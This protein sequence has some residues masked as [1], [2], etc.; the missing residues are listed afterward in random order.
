VSGY[1]YIAIEGPIG[2][3]KSTLA[4]L[5]QGEFEA[6][7]L[8]EV[9]E[10]N[11]FLSNFYADRDQYAFQVQLFFLLSRYRQQSVVPRLVD[12]G[13]VIS[14]YT[15]AKD[16]LFAHLNVRGDEL[17]LYD[18]LHALLS[19]KLLEPDLIVYL[20][21]SHNALMERI[22]IRDREYERNMDAEYMADLSRAYD[23]FFADYAACP[24]VTID[25][26]DLNIVRNPEDLGVILER[27]RSVLGH[28]THQRPLLDVGADSFQERNAALFERAE[29]RLP[30]LQSWHLAFDR[31][32]G[33]STDLSVNFICLQEEIGELAT[34]VLGV[35]S[36]QRMLQRDGMEARQALRSAAAE[37]EAGLA[38]EMADCLA[39]LLK[40][41]NYV[42]IDLESAYLAKMRDNCDR[43][44]PDRALPERARREG[45]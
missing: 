2:V 16:S 43:V 20:K 21:A 19:E 40:L 39:Y 25:T 33:F 7:L 11:P 14:D 45:D 38:N 1:S 4:R 27:I 32:K 17:D 15:F 10:E 34:E 28:G 42:G 29:R 41:A 31:E 12:E 18:H 30:D 23:R 44:W 36:R 8:M 3:G 24:V 6:N 35:L 9:F 26:T 13:N 37:Q 22:A 5:I